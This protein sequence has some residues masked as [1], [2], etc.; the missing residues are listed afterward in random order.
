MDSIQRPPPDP[1]VGLPDRVELPPTTVAG[2]SFESD[3]FVPPSTPPTNLKHDLTRP[4]PT[5]PMSPTG[6]MRSRVKRV[7][8]SFRQLK[9]S[10]SFQSEREW[11]V[12]GQLM[13]ND[14]ELRISGSQI[15]NGRGPPR[16]SISVS[17]SDSVL[18][19][20]LVR[21]PILQSLE[22]SQSNGARPPLYSRS[23]SE[24]DSEDHLSG[25]ATP[26]PPSV[27]HE[28]KHPGFFSSRHFSLSSLQQ[29]ILKCAIAY[30]VASLFTFLPFLSGLIADIT[31]DGESLPSPSA[32]LVATM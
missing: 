21:S 1:P 27:S 28:Q 2:Q 7:A 23:P 13:D 20:N 16:L 17:S 6:S 3:G 9:S 11:T 8:S 4:S 12:F 14:G 29:K 24:C 30:L 25:V 15:G 31:S 26:I 22:I 10:G 18:G 32:H 5:P 19:E